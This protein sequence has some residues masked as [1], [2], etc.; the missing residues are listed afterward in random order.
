MK[1][2]VEERRIVKILGLVGGI[3]SGKSTVAAILEEFGAAV[4]DADRITGACLEE[5]EICRR[6]EEKFGKA[7]FGED[8]RLDRRSLADRVFS[9]EVARENLHRIVHPEI[10]NRMRTELETIR[11]R[12][13]KG[14]IVIDAPLL[15]ESEFKALCDHV[16]MIQASRAVRIERTA[17][18]GWD[19]GELKRRESFQTGL[20]DKEAAS[21]SVIDNSGSIEELRQEVK[22]LF[23]SLNS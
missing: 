9:S 10:R 2:S 23:E 14:V 16:V 4:I 6:I 11:S 21:N 3:G 17:A 20:A 1:S 13:R 19:A 8:G 15:L 7:V 22:A 12:R 5:A 18:R